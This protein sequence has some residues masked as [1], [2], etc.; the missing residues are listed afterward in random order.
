MRIRGKKAVFFIGGLLTIFFPASKPTPAGAS[1]EK[2][3]TRLFLTLE[4]ALPAAGRPVLL[5]FFSTTCLVCWD[6]LFEA[7]AMIE[8]DDFPVELVGVSLERPEDLESFL[9][10]Y[11]FPYPVVSDR[12]RLVH[13]RFRVRAAPFK[14][15]LLD[16]AV[17]YRD[18]LRQNPKTQRERLR[19]CLI[20]LT[21]K[22]RLH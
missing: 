15:L 17:L 10:K 13:R 7:K 22:S 21:S 9:K 2:A 11:S 12:K 3:P 16:E 6:D 18:D 1:I 19:Q 14:L 4:E 5:V 8:A 20:G